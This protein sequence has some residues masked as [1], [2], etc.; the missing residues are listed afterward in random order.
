MGTDE[1]RIIGYTRSTATFWIAANYLRP[2]SFWTS[3]S[4]GKATTGDP[5]R[6]Q[7]GAPGT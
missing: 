6:F 1:L 3:V 2:N 4:R 7:T 5:G